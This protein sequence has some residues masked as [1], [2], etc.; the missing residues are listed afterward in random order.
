MNTAE[1]IELMKVNNDKMNFQ[2][3]I[4]FQMRNWAIIIAIGI[5][6]ASYSLT[7]K[8]G[9][10]LLISSLGLHVF[11]LIILIYLSNKDKDWIKYFIVFRERACFIEKELI[12]NAQLNAN[13]IKD[14]YF[15]YQNIDSSELKDGLINE[16][17]KKTDLRI[18]KI[19]A[20][21]IGITVLS[22]LITVYNGIE[23]LV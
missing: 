7:I 16:D 14:K 21:L 12:C 6:T 3:N 11:L 8:D 23:K 20:Y 5:I 9:I 4:C 15:T 18:N 10:E 17:F 2:Q 22:L 13:K 1:L 19:Y